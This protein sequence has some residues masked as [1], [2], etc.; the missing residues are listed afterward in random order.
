MPHKKGSILAITMGFALVFTLLGSSA[1]YLSTLQSE[2]QEKRILETQAFW[3]AEAGASRALSALK[4]EIR[5]DLYN[6]I[7]QADPGSVNDYVKNQCYKKNKAL[8]LLTQYGQFTLSEDG[9]TVT[10]QVN[11]SQSL[12]LGAGVLGNYSAT[13]TLGSKGVTHP[14]PPG[15]D[16]VYNLSFSC[17]ITSTGSIVNSTIQKTVKLSNE[18]F[19]ITI[20]QYN[21]ARFALFTNHHTYPSGGIIW[22]TKDTNFTGPVH[23]NEHFNFA[24]NP[25]GHFTEMVTQVDRKAL[26]RNNG[27]FK[28]LDD[29]HN[30]NIDVPI[31]G[32][33]PLKPT[34][35]DPTLYSRL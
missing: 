31:F 2:A 26:F 30:G 27:N 34:E 19:Y 1:I 17:N 14:K 8:P 33:N 12:D 16:T 5:S 22:F 28:E 29:Y 13:I 21:F 9:K 3:L 10:L 11:L 32:W 20:Q 35:S 23:T 25:S 7:Q 24:N 15:N 18:E 4:N 6:N